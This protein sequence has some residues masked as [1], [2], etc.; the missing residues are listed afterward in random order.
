[1]TSNRA[2]RREFLKTVGTGVAVTGA[3]AAEQSGSANAADTVNRGFYVP[4]SVSAEAQAVIRSFDPS[5]RNVR[6]PPPG[7]LAAWKEM[8]ARF[9][10]EQQENN[11]EVVQH[12]GA[13]VERIKLGGVPVLDIKPKGWQ[14]TA[15]LLVY[16]HGGAYALFSASSTLVC[17]VPVAA[18]TGYR[19]LSIDYTLAPQAKF[20]TITD[21]VISVFEAIYRKH[22]PKDVALYGDSAGGGM[23]AGTV[24]KM[25][26][27]GL[28]LPAAVIL[29][30]PWSDITEVGDTY[31]TLREADPVLNYPLAL[32][33]AAGAYAPPED[34]KHPYVS[35]VY[36]DYSKGFPPTLI[37]AGT[38]ETFLSNAIRHYQAF[39]QAGIPVKLDLYE[40]M[41][42][43]FQA[44]PWWLPE[45]K[46][47]RQKVGRFLKQNLMP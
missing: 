36:G 34:Q 38:K 5:T 26:D 4:T 45:S 35:P 41:W 14:Q 25:R 37:Q 20:Q 32:K 29:W 31:Q 40:G 33:N 21:Q 30:S 11:R 28:D 18:E 7:D 9:E 13:S 8:Q 23:A 46:L 47:A 22:Q 10:R 1:M 3:F 16:T 42:H 17:A 19:I 43:V 27:R 2:N 15:K 12:Y 44:F 6:T 24:L 39:D